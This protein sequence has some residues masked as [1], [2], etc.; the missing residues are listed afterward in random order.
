[1]YNSSKTMKILGNQYPNMY[2]TP[3]VMQQL[4]EI[5]DAHTEANG[6]DIVMLLVDTFIWGY[7]NGVH[8]ERIKRAGRKY[9]DA[10]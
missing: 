3:E 6:D 1:M 5:Y 2:I 8:G 9:A 4:K 10:V 7:I